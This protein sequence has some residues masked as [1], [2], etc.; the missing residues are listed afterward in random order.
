MITA[1]TVPIENKNKDAY[2]VSNNLHFFYTSND[3]WVVPARVTDRRYTVLQVSGAHADDKGYFQ[4]IFG[5][6]DGDGPAHLLHFLLNHKYQRSLVR[7]PLRSAA[8]LEQVMQRR[9]TIERWWGEKLF[10]DGADCAWFGTDVHKEDVYKLFV[11][12]FQASGS[13]HRMPTDGDF[14]KR[15]RQLLGDPLADRKLGSDG[16]RKKVV[17]FPPLD[18]CREAYAQEFKATVAEMMI[19]LRG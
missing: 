15:A 18:K 1:A 6:L 19:A 5:A 8:K 10:E 11:R 4:P 17:G 16:S 3:P 2:E 13:K 14:W 7:K 9:S 12:D